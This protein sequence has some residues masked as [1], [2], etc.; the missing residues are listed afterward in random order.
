MADEE[1]RR[2]LEEAGADAEHLDPELLQRFEE[3]QSL[4]AEIE[5]RYLDMGVRLLSDDM[6]RRLDEQTQARLERLLGRD[7]RGVRVHTGERA[8]RA[9]SAMG[10]QA[11]ALGDRDVFFGAGG[12]D[13]SSRQG[14]GL[15]A[16]EVAHTVEAGVP[17]GAQVGFEGRP[18]ESGR[19]EG[20]AQETESR[21]LAQEE[22]AAPASAAQAEEAPGAG[23]GAAKGAARPK[24][25]DPVLIEG[26]AWREFLDRVR[27]DM[28][29]H[30]GF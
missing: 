10:A 8:Q 14:I 21:A 29:R 28:E 9:A 1:I 13:P 3:G 2:A 5:H 30:G 4:G 20:F 27:R 18:S 26:E 11:F 6:P 17:G 16:H 15:L 12:Y 25:L 19:G 23:P 7:L 24:H 22:G